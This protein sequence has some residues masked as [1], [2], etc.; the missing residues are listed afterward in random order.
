MHTIK[1]DLTTRVVDY[2]LGDILEREGKG[3]VWHGLVING[4]S[5]RNYK[6]G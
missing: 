3:K 1:H 2:T 6:G 5:G 4:E